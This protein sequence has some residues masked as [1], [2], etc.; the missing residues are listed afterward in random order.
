MH[1]LTHTPCTVIILD[2]L[3]PHSFTPRSKPT[4]STN[5]PSHLNT[6]STPGLPSRSW[7][8]TGLIM[9]LDLFLVFFLIFL[10]VP[11]G[12]LSWLNVRFLLHV[13]YSISYCIVAVITWSHC[14]YYHYGP[15]G[16]WDKVHW[17]QYNSASAKLMLLLSLFITSDKGGG[18]FFCPCSFVCLCVW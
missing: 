8:R 17:I 11:C 10:L 3:L 13:K 16:P 2:F 1:T 5:R 12:G 6:S 9:L 15:A 18:K 14:S 4:F 7:D